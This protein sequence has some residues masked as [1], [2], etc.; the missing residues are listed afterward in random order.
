MEGRLY[1]EMIYDPDAAALRT[2]SILG[3]RGVERVVLELY[4]VSER[5]RPKVREISGSGLYSPAI[6]HHA[7]MRRRGHSRH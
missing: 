6:I 2:I 7:L 1:L 5:E 4:W 3:L